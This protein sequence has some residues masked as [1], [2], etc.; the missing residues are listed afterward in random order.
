MT[1]VRITAR[2]W[3]GGWELWHEEECWTQVA[4]LADAR[5][6]V[7][8]Y[9]DTT[10]ESIDHSGWEI[11]VIPDVTSTAQVK[12]ARQAAQAAARLQQ[13]AASAWRQAALSLRAEGLSIADAATIMGVSKGR[14]SQLT[15]AR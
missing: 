11:T 2:R 10:D 15:A 12:A 4:R 1:E 9:L 3:S 5:Q 6:Q 13:E 7:I 14:V 8:D